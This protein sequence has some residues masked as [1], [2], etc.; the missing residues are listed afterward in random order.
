MLTPS[1]TVT[2]LT[3]LSA[4]RELPVKGDMKVTVGQKVNVNDVVGESVKEGELY[5]IKVAEEL[6][7]E[8][9]KAVEVLLKK[10]GEPVTEGEKIAIHRGLFGL[11]SSEVISPVTG[12]VEFISAKSGHV[13]VRMPST[14]HTLRAFIAGRVKE[15]EVNKGCVIESRGALIQGAFGVGGER[16]GNIRVLNVP[17]DRALLAEHIGDDVVA[18]DILVGGTKPN[19]EFFLKAAQRG[20]VGIIVGGCD[21]D[22][23]EEVSGKAHG[24]AVTGDEPI[25]FTAILTEGFG[26]VPI[27]QKVIDVAKKYEGCAASIQGMTQVRAGAV[28][29]F[30]MISGVEGAGELIENVSA[31]FEVGKKVRLIQMSR[32]GEQGTIAELPVQPEKIA[33]GAHVRVLKVALGNGQVITVPRANVEVMT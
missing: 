24:V 30:V 6:G 31:S 25:S 21:D 1:L 18:G 20:V 14:V 16:I 12:V 19:V 15:V 13:G 5:L 29:P 2:A 22:V 28:R 26:G 33:T 11:F 3:T 17:N 27:S 4:R 8:A 23:L 9:D 10:I 7:I 32:F